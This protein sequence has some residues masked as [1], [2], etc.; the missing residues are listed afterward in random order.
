MSRCK[1]CNRLLDPETLS[2]EKPDG[3]PED[4][5]S[6]C[7]SK[8]SSEYNILYDHE[9]GQAQVTGDAPTPFSYYFYE[10]FD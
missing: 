6:N 1:S 10:F 3:S 5:C 7:K 2:S 9:Y 4:M 8:S